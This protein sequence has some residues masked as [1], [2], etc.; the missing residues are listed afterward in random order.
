M[1]RS[2][3]TSNCTG[4]TCSPFNVSRSSRLRV[5]A[6][7]SP[8]P[9]STNAETSVRPSPR[10]APVIS[11]RLPSISMYFR[12]LVTA[13]HSGELIKSRP[14]NT[15]NYNQ[16]NARQRLAVY[17][18]TECLS[19]QHFSVLAQLNPDHQTH[20]Q[21]RD[22]CRRLLHPAR[23]RNLDFARKARIQPWQKQKY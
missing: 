14:N 2:L 4:V 5:P 9:A 23:H 1:S 7:T 22:N 13:L 21:H 19:A 12:D 17:S 20:R 16:F 3:V 8:A 15:P 11:T 6:I 18:L 10:P